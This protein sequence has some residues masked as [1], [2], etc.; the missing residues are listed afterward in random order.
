MIV[1]SSLRTCNFLF[2]NLQLIVNQDLHVS[3]RYFVRLYIH[4]IDIVND[5]TQKNKSREQNSSSALT[6]TSNEVRCSFFTFSSR[7]KYHVPFASVF[8]FGDSSI[9]L[10]LSPHC[11][12]ICSSVCCWCK[13]QHIYKRPGQ[14]PSQCRGNSS[15]TF[16]YIGFVGVC[17]EQM[18]VCM[19]H[20][21][22]LH[23]SSEKLIKLL[24]R[25]GT[26]PFTATRSLSASALVPREASSLLSRVSFQKTSIPI[27]DLS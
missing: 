17:V 27:P 12:L 26:P 13:V 11:Y 21:T 14:Q 10:P 20:P 4:A 16:L 23:S 22:P 9:S 24:E 18:S 1:L 7:R 15:Q 25:Q 2:R 19:R 6:N 3:I 5:G 8:L